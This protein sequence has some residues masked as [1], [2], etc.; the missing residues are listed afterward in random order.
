MKKLDGLI[1]AETTTDDAVYVGSPFPGDLRRKD[2]QRRVVARPVD[3]G[4]IDLEYGETLEPHV[5]P[6][7]VLIPHCRTYGQLMRAEKPIE[8]QIRAHWRS[9]TRHAQELG[10]TAGE[11]AAKAKAVRKAAARASGAILDSERDMAPAN[12]AA[13]LG[14]E[15]LIVVL[16]AH[17]YS[18]ERFRNKEEKDIVEAAKLLP[19][20]PWVEGVRGIGALGL[21]LIVGALGAPMWPNYANPAKVWKRMGLAVLSDGKAQRRVKDKKLALEA[22]FN[23][24]RR[25]IMHNVGESLV[26][27]NQTPE[28]EPLKYRALY[29]ERKKY[30]AARNPE[31]QKDPEKGKG[32]NNKRALRYMEKKFLVDLWVEW[33]RVG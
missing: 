22:G 2:T 7:A 33:K 21:G 29:L 17:R 9:R 11:I 15:P 4:R 24:R 23:P 6:I 16:E 13:E 31:T 27:Q 20:W 30:E 3:G 14:V 1:G 19:V 25:S 32:L 26:K 12:I 28:K 18:L 8:N 5:D 10:L